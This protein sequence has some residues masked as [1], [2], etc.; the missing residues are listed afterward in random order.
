MAVA[1]ANDWNRET[2]DKRLAHMKTCPYCAETDLAND[3]TVCKHCG[4]EIG[5][6]HQLKA[7]GQ[8]MQAI[9]CGLTLL[10]TIPI[11]L[12]VLLGTCAR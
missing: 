2:L 8:Q 11:V 4:K 9:G 3:A 12:L 10:I 5:P 1:R 7:A 6:G